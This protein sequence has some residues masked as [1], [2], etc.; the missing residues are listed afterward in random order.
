[1]SVEATITALV[2]NLIEAEPHEVPPEAHLF[3]E[4]N[5]DSVLAIDLV[6]ELE[7]QFGIAI[8]DER[9]KELSSVRAITTIVETY[10]A[11]AKAG[12]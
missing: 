8:P 5:M 10:L 4:L 7:K 9:M 12:I 1:M 11:G 2:A 3:K 6:T